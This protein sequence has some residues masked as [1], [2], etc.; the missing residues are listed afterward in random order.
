MAVKP[1]VELILIFFKKCVLLCLAIQ[2][3]DYVLSELKW[4]SVDALGLFAC[5]STR[6]QSKL[7][8]L[9]GKAI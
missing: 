5:L 7:I 2:E 1:Y 6:R 3:R 4:G 8:N 9:E